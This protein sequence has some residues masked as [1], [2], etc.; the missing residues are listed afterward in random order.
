MSKLLDNVLLSVPEYVKLL[1]LDDEAD[2]YEDVQNELDTAH[3]S[4]RRVV[5]A[6]HELVVPPANSSGNSNEIFFKLMTSLGTT[7]CEEE[8][9]PMLRALLMDGS[10]LREDVFVNWYIRWVLGGFDGD[11]DDDMEYSNYDKANSGAESGEG[12]G[13]SNV[14]WSVTPDTG[15]ADGIRWKCSSCLVTNAW[16]V[17][18]CVACDSPAPHAPTAPSSDSKSAMFGS[19]APGITSSGFT[20]GAPSSF[21]S[22]SFSSSSFTPESTTS[23]TSS[24]FVFGSGVGFTPP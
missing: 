6:D 24:G 19:S 8:H 4:W 3:A 9:E 16:D 10:V 7:Y 17:H 20:F 1:G 11:N 12:S 21:T 23:S 22:T 15:A 18:R 13:W 14:K 2:S 5:G